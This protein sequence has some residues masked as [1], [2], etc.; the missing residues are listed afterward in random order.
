MFKIKQLLRTNFL[1]IVGYTTPELKAPGQKRVHF[2]AAI[3]S[4]N[5]QINNNG[6]THIANKPWLIDFEKKKKSKLQ[7]TLEPIPHDLRKSFE[8]LETESSKLKSQGYTY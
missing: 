7:P 3:D 2:S 4:R 1:K 6:L 8:A 5:S